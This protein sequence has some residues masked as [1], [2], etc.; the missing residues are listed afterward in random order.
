ME[1]RFVFLSAYVSETGLADRPQRVF[2]ATEG[3]IDLGQGIG[4]RNG[5]RNGVPIVCLA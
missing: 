4:C 5:F 1:V 2:D 3:K